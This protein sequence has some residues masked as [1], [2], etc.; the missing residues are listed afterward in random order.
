MYDP[1]Q[2]LRPN[3]V[4]V[5]SHKWGRFA[6]TFSQNQ[7][8]HFTRILA[9]DCLWMDGEH[10]SLVDSILH[11]LS[12]A[13][14]TQAWVIAGFHT[15]RA[16][17][18]AFL[19]TATMFYLV[20]HPTVLEKLQADLRASFPILLSIQPVAAENHRYLRA[21]MDEAMRLSP[22]AP[23]NIPR[24]VGQGG[25]KVVNEHLSENVYVGVPNFSIFRDE[26]SFAKPHDFIPERWILDPANGVSE[27]SVKQ[28]HQA[29]QSFSLGPRHCIGKH[30]AMKEVSFIL[31]TLLWL[32]EVDKIEGSG[33]LHKHLPGVNGKVVMEQ[34]DVYTSLEEG[35]EVKLR[36]RGDMKL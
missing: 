30:L 31:A 12:P 2:R 1:P 36:L 22:P 27:E 10:Q 5:H 21:C 7:A 29:F 6:D 3:G 23:T 13:P 28:A 14:D 24:V 16:K 20:Q 8:K 9:A 15:G 17:V 11:F 26:H 34:S 33:L 35:P 4:D 25:I 32:F 18:A 19:L